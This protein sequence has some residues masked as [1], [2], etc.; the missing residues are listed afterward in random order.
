LLVLLDNSGVIRRQQAAGA[1][2][3]TEHFCKLSDRG[4]YGLEHL[5]IA[6]AGRTDPGGVIMRASGNANLKLPAGTGM[7]LRVTRDTKPVSA[8]AQ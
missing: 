8:A 5:G 4:T 3:E 6:H 2:K 7:L 1:G